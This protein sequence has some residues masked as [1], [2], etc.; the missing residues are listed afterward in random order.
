M[1][2]KATTF[3]DK[4]PDAVAKPCTECP[5]RRDATPGHLGPHAAKEWVDMAHGEGPI[6]CHMTIQHEDQDWS[7]LKQCAGSAIFRGNICKSPRH[8]K[9]AV[10]ETDKVTVFGW[11][12]QFIEHHTTTDDVSWDVG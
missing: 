12:D 6:A 5:W 7:E 1:I 3:L 2:R 11:D 4:L 9:V 10:F 8:A